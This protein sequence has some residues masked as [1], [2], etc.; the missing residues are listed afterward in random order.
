[1]IYFILLL[2]AICLARVQYMVSKFN[3]MAPW[4]G[5]GAIQGVLDKSSDAPMVYRVLVPWILGRNYTLCKYNLVQTILIW[6][7]LISLYLAWGLQI[8]FLSMVFLMITFWYDYWDWSIEVMALALALT[9]FPLALFGIIILGLSR[10]TAPLVGLVYALHSGDWAL[11][12]ILSVIGLWT[13]LIVRL[14]QGNHPLYCKR[15]MILNNIEL[16]KKGNIS[17]WLSIFIC[18]LGMLALLQASSRNGHLDILIVPVI[19]I[20]GWTMAKGN[21]TRVFASI[22]PYAALFLSGL[23]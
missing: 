17:A 9:I 7:M 12:F 21:E 3:L 4:S 13:L 16:L 23:L 10:E 15:W 14:I 11:G 6:M 1:M 22:I 8:I 5:Y 20:L 2:F 19:A 18:L